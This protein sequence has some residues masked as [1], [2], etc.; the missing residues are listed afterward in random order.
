[1]PKRLLRSRA[2]SLC[3]TRRRCG[4]PSCWPSL[5]T[6]TTT[7]STGSLCGLTS[8]CTPN[9]LVSSFNG[10]N[11]TIR[12]LIL[13]SMR[14]ARHLPSPTSPIL[15]LVLRSRTTRAL[16]SSVQAHRRSAIR[17][18]GKCCFYIVEASSLPLR[19]H[20]WTGRR[21]RWSGRTWASR[22][23]WALGSTTRTCTPTSMAHLQKYL[24]RWVLYI[25]IGFYWMT[26]V[27]II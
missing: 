20:I 17:W 1:M 5:S 4:R 13:H 15:V 26:Y 18:R 27:S 22:T 12:R 11:L 3:W 19:M 14:L 6:R 21:C 23:V 2:V 10:N 9:M 16:F 8:R 7:S 25:M 24:S